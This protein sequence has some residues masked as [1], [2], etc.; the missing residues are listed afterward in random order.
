MR[1]LRNQTNQAT[2]L[3]RLQIDELLKFQ[4]KV[5]EMVDCL[6]MFIKPN[7]YGFS[8]ILKREAPYKLSFFQYVKEFFKSCIIGIRVWCICHIG[9]IAVTVLRCLVGKDSIQ[10]VRGPISLPNVR[11]ELPRSAGGRGA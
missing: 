8:G 5:F 3:S 11:R 9:M 4:D 2:L 1:R 10:M 6:D 7:Y